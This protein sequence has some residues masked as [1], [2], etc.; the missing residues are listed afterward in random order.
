[1]TRLL[2]VTA[3][4]ALSVVAYFMVFDPAGGQAILMDVGTFVR[5]LVN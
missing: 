3:L 5:S 2:L 4:A 1:M